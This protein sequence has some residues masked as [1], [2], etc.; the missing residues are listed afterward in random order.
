MRLHFF[1]SAV[2]ANSKMDYSPRSGRSKITESR[3]EGG[4]I[5][6]KTEKNVSTGFV[7]SSS[8]LQSLISSKLNVLLI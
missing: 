3:R 6:M 4:V 2:T 5:Q 1:N 7:T 8:P